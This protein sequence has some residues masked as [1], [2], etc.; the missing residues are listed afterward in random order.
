MLN[1]DDAKD[2]LDG[3]PSVEFAFAYGSG[4]VE[5]GGYKYTPDDPSK[6]PMLDL[7]L[8]VE[9]AEKWHAD[10]M[11][12][13][14]SHYSPLFP[15]GF[16][17]IAKFQEKIPAYLWFNAYVPMTTAKFRGRLMKYGVITKHQMLN[18]LNNW[19]N[20]Y[21][22]GRLQKP[23]HILKGNQVIEKALQVNL[24]HAVRTSLLMLPSK[25]NEIDLYISIA[26]LSYVGDPRMYVG[27]NPQKVG[28]K[29][30][31]LKPACV[32]KCRLSSTATLTG[33]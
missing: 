10:N 11:I 25:F 26:S 22:A 18:D 5:Q 7:I 21:I 32:L 31:S 24:E 2:L 16:K 13:N 8:V 20:L 6:L 30:L 28:N 19:T 4:V 33:Y 23:V 3:F 29:L 17:L 1:G 27:E 12:K 14:K 15:I 9:N